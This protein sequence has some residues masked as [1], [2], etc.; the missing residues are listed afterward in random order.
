MTCSSGPP[1]IPGNTCL[2]TS[3][4][5]ASWHR[6]IPPRG[7]RSVLCVVVV[8]ICACGTDAQDAAR[9]ARRVERRGRVDLRVGD[10][11][12][13]QPCGHEPGEVRHVHDEDGRSEEHT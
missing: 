13:M 9:P 11:R 3:L 10:R 6:M 8:T 7:P 2:S 4:A 1:W 5:N 12:R